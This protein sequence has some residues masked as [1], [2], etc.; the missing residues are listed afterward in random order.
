MF[1]RYADNVKGCRV[2]DLENAKDKVIR[3]VNLNEREVDGIYDTQAIMPE[4]VIYVIKDNS[5]PLE[6]ASYCGLTYKA[7]ENQVTDVDMNY[8]KHTLSVVPTKQQEDRL[9]FQPKLNSSRRRR[10]PMLKIGNGS[11]DE[12]SKK[13]SDGPPSSKSA[14]I[15]E[16][17]RIV[18]AVLAYAVSID[19]D[20]DHVCS[21]NGKRRYSKVA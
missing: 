16:D 14:R 9:V 3:S 13:G 17:G 19:V 8:M 4:S 1:L 12:I 15:D 18:E 11:E 2:S 21:S 6:L 10:E 20:T 7:Y 5:A